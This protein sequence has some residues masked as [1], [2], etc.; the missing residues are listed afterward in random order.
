M[1]AAV[2]GFRTHLVATGI[3]GDLSRYGE[4]LY[5]EVDADVDTLFYPNPMMLDGTPKPV[6]PD[7]IPIKAGVTRCIPMALYNFKADAA[8]TVVAYRQ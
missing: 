3:E 5:A 1:R 8:V 4:I 2:A 7:G 6:A